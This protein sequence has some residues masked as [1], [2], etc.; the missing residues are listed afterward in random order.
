RRGNGNVGILFRTK[1]E[2]FSDKINFSFQRFYIVHRTSLLDEVN[3][4][5]RMTASYRHYTVHWHINMI[6]STTRLIFTGILVEKT[7]LVRFINQAWENMSTF[8]VP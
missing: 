7:N 6:V 5:G 4:L 3:R 1:C 8:K 2:Q